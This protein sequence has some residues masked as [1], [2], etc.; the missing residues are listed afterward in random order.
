MSRFKAQ[1]VV[2]YLRRSHSGGQ[3]PELSTEIKLA[4]QTYAE[5]CVMCHKVSGDGGTVGPDLSLVGTRRDEAF[6]RSMI[7][8]PVAAT[9]NQDSAMPDFKDRLSAEQINALA[10]YLASRR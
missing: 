7:E 2:A 4:A 10:R 9:G 3:P 6:I 8:D 5:N 1:A